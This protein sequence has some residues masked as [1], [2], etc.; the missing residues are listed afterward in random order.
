LPT[1][2]ESS[3]TAADTAERL[4][5]SCAAACSRASISIFFMF[6]IARITRCDLSPSDLL[7]RSSSL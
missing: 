5:Y 2:V 3:L 1:A 4:T 7:H 6:N